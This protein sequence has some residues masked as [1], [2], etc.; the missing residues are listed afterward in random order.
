MEL[1]KKV[2]YK[3]NV[4]L[5][6]KLVPG[7]IVV[8]DGDKI[9]SVLDRDQD[10]NLPIV[11]CG[12]NYIA[13]GFI[14]IHFHG[15]LGRDV[16]DASTE[17][18]E[19]LASYQASQGVTGFLGA[20]MLSSVDSTLAAIETLKKVTNLDLDSE[21][22]GAYVEGPFINVKKKGAQNPQYIDVWTEEKIHRLT[23]AAQ[24]MIT[25]FPIAPEVPS[26]MVRIKELKRK[27]FIL[28]IGHSM[29]TYEQASL[30]FRTGITH[31]TH[32]FNAMADF[33]HREPGVIGAVLDSKSVTAEII[34]DGMH[35]HP[36]SIRMALACKGTE[37]IC[38]VTDSVK[39][40]GLGNGDF[41]LGKDQISVEGD[42]A[43]L[44]NSDI[45]AGGVVSLSQAMRNMLEWTNLSLPQIVQMIT[46]TPA[47]ILGLED[48]CGSLER[49]KQ[50]SLVFLDDEFNVIKT[51]L[52]GHEV[53]SSS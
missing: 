13:P 50:S 8:I 22:L 3:G 39:T 1:T 48:R 11:D 17:N 51:I 47:R 33:N 32:L 49:N 46:L 34:A 16:M 45:L 31:A 28:A 21:I 27:G 38:L 6:D 10:T 2:A 24:G 12:E 25:V 20:T 18:L 30:S 41:T 44:S 5:A 37:K 23:E 4:I 7:G 19:I 52:K 36:A 9:V 35:V 53:Y 29:A 40:T 43:V 42:R 14:D 26:F 15:A